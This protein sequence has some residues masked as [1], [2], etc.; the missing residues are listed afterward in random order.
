MQGVQMYIDV[1]ASTFQ[2][3]VIER[4]KSVPVVVDFWAP[5][6]GPCRTL[7][8]VLDKLASGAQGKWVLAKLNTDENQGLA[9]RFQIQGIP[10]VKAFVNGV[11]VDEF[12]GALPEPQVRA[13]ISKVVPD[14][15]TQLAQKAAVAKAV[16]D[17]ATAAMLYDDALRVDPQQPDAIVFAAQSALVRGENEL[18]G[19]LLT[20]LKPS[21]RA[22]RV[23]LLATLRFALQAKPDAEARHAVE[24]SV[25]N[26][27]D[28][29]VLRAASGEWRDAL[30]LFLSVLRRDR[31]F[32]GDAGRKAMLDVFDAVG[33]ANPLADEFRRKLSMELFK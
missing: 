6:C 12:V 20:Q 18:A 32:G 8:P 27:Y 1:S 17:V 25:E 9:Q 16:G 15:A 2:T 22:Q 10:A 26:T 4:S 21:D 3:E 24:Q 11:V 23:G 14:E 13:W 29:G 31:G 7:G 28:L 19:K 5:W 33:Q 30:E